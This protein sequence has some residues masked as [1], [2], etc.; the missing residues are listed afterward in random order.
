MD[1]LYQSSRVESAAFAERGPSA[2]LDDADLA[3]GW[4]FSL[5]VAACLSAARLAADWKNGPLG[6]E[7]WLALAVLSA[8]AATLLTHA[9]RSA[10]RA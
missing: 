1:L 4:F 7:A 9:I 2:R 6:G 5:L 3:R 10:I 8:T